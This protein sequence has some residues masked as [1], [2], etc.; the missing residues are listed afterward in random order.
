V[1]RGQLRQGG[2]VTA[3]VDADRRDAI[4]R[5]HTATHLLHAALREVLGSHVRQA[6]SLV[7]PD[8]LRFDFHHGTPVSQPDL[9]RIERLVNE[10]VYRNTGVDTAVMRTDE[11][12]AAGAFG[13]PTMFGEG[14]LFWGLDSLPNLEQ[15]LRGETPPAFAEMSRW[16]DL[17]ASAQRKP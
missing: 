17:G 13:V 11:A 6:G 14:E 7:A 8:R 12:I 15:R 16:A 5:N 4:R 10:Q 2:T 3:R 9:A 1:E